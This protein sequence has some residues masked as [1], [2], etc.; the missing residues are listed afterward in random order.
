MGTGA[1]REDNQGHEREG[2]WTEPTDRHSSPSQRPSQ[3]DQL[4]GEDSDGDVLAK[5]ALGHVGG[6]T[7]RQGTFNK[8]LEERGKTYQPNL[9][10]CQRV[11]CGYCSTAL[12]C[13]CFVFHSA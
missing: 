1:I 7:E 13:N 2:N 10:G 12:W 9:P 5:M 11:N 6:N 3:G 8:A 4:V